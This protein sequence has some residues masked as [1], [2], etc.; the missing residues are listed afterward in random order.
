MEKKKLKD[1]FISWIIKNKVKSAIMGGLV[2]LLLPLLV[3]ELLY[4]I[5]GFC[6]LITTRFE[7][8]DILSYWR[9][10][11]VGIGTIALGALA[12]YQNSIINKQAQD[13]QKKA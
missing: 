8:T 6:T 10:F 12:P 5:G 3:I 1:R 7:A 13:A 4:R 2:I 9:A 11:L